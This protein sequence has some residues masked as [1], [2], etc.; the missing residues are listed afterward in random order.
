MPPIAIDLFHASLLE[1]FVGDAEEALMR[2]LIFLGPVTVR[3]ITL[4]EGPG[5][6]A[7]AQEAKHP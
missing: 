2:L 1:R 5:V 4:H 6:E 7:R 3:A